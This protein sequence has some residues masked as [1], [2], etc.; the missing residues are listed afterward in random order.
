MDQ[1]VPSEQEQESS[2]P[3]T[4]QEVLI[5]CAQD[6]CDYKG[7]DIHA[8]IHEIHPEVTCITCFRQFNGPV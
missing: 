7:T 1:Q 8:H 5:E 3:P 4:V 2:Q 6:N